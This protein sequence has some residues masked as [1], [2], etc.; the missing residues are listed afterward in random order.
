MMG[1]N[2]YH[3]VYTICL[4]KVGKCLEI[5]LK[6]N[7]WNVWNE[8]WLSIFV[9]WL[10]FS[11]VLSSTLSFKLNLRSLKVEHTTTQCIMLLWCFLWVSSFIV[12][13]GSAWIVMIGHVIHWPAS[14]YLVGVHKLVG[15]Y[16]AVKSQKRSKKD[17]IGFAL[18]FCTLQNSSKQAVSVVY[19]AIGVVLVEW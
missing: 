5:E 10:N 2:Q 14:L 15:A 4:E 13:Y 16:K 8:K 1:K 9:K 12:V 7:L 19:I 18:L 6:M 17:Q 11:S 3:T